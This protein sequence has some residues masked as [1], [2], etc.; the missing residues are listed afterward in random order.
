VLIDARTLPG[1]TVLECEV[2]VVGGGAAG[3]SAALEMAE[4]GR[5]VVLLEAG[6]PGPEA[7]AQNSYR[8]EIESSPGGDV[9]PPLESVRQKLLGGT[10]SSWGGRC[11]PLDE[12]DLARWPLRL[13][14]LEPYWRRAHPYLHLGEYEYS[15][16]AALPDSG[17]FIVG[18]GGSAV[19]RDD[20]VWRY[21]L[22]THFG[23][24]HARRLREL[25]R[26]RVYCHA[27]VL[28]FEFAP[29]GAAV[30]A[31]RASGAPDHQLRVEARAY[32]L[33]A[34]GLETT[35]LL[36]L[37]ER[38]ARGRAA[39]PSELVGRGYMT[40]LDGALGRIRF[41]SQPPRPVYA[42]E[43]SHDGVYCR[44]LVALTAEARRQQG[45]PN[46]GFVFTAP[47]AR[48]PAHGDGLL[49]AY[50]L[51]KEFLYRS[52]LGFKS[53]RYGIGA[54]PLAV[55]PHVRNVGRDAPRL[56]AFGVGWTRRRLLA[57]RKLPS[58]LAQSRSNE[59]SIL[60][61]AEQSPSDG[62]R[63]TLS[64]ECD[65]SG[66]PRLRVAW[67]ATESD[68]TGIA[69]A[70]GLIRDELQRQ[71]LASVDLPATPERLRTENGGFMAGTHA[72]GTT[73]MGTAARNGVV[74]ADCRLHG[75]PN[76]YVASSS[77]FPTSGFAAPTLTIVALALRICDTIDRSLR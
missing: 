41:R 59:Y 32:V 5:D 24:A 60:F 47:P 67:H 48:D 31:A 18:L 10:T 68:V 49:S 13:A 33:A 64:D 51:T 1:G 40:H 63:L 15:T 16:S 3:I 8:G 43:V 45:L 6:G 55:W 62:N 72:M 39:W 25:P 26:L 75:V 58:F 77:V 4:K 76:L 70:L 37:S 50:A 53:A 73:P 2:C 36:L 44:R 23:K 21:S 22:P 54:E 61:N 35:R 42:Y 7:D 9:H 17:R 11:L 52:K 74:D 20:L 56:A 27:N 14:D 28:R 12:Q 34:G 46:L 30:S 57:S 71:G 66:L 38:Y 65:A 69:R 29:D 19:V